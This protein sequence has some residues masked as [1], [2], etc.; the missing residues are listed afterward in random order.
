MA[1]CVNISAAIIERRISETDKH[2]L[3]GVGPF[4]TG[5]FCTCDSV[6]N[7]LRFDFRRTQP[8]EILFAVSEDIMRL[9]M[10]SHVH[11]MILADS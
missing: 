3:R 7:V 11:E 6:S 9:G 8:Y 5:I 4:G 1:R 2:Q 10:S